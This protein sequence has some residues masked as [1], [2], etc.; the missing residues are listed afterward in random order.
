MM[1]TPLKLSFCGDSVAQESR[2]AHEYLLS[3]PRGGY[4]TFR[5][6]AQRTRIYRLSQHCARISDSVRMMREAAESGVH[7]KQSGA[8]KQLQDGLQ[9]DGFS[10]PSVEWVRQRISRAMLAMRDQFSGPGEMRVSA[11]VTA[12][13]RQPEFYAFA[14]LL[15]QPDPSL[16]VMIV[17]RSHRTNP[18]AKD[19]TW[20]RQREELERQIVGTVDEVVMEE[21]GSISEGISSNFFVIRE[22][23]KGKREIWTAPEGECLMGTMRASVIEVCSR[24]GYQ[25]VYQRP[26]LTDLLDP[27]TRWRACFASST[28]RIVKPCS[29]L[30]ISPEARGDCGGLAESYSMDV[31]EAEKVMEAVRE[32]MLA[33]A[34]EY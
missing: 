29:E 17:A 32:E 6:C 9:D 24:L 26:R 30:R 2:S 13:T 18:G 27:S 20:M 16:S 8:G 7:E 12:F 3:L 23:E 15:P 31:S 28:S 22:G 19:I 10:L 34:E 14:E 21:G 33:E 4:T 5:T 1:Q 11:L 25:M